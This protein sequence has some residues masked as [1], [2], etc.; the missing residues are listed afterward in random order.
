MSGPQG[1]PGESAYEIYKRVTG[2]SLNEAEWIASLKGER[3]EKGETGTAGA[4]GPQ[5][6]AG[7][8]G[9]SDVISTVECETTTTIVIKPSFQNIEFPSAFPTSYQEGLRIR[10]SG[11]GGYIEGKITSI[12]SVT[13]L[14]MDSDNYSG[15]LNSRLNGSE[16]RVQS[17]SPAVRAGFLFGAGKGIQKN[18]TNYFGPG[19]TWDGIGQASADIV[20]IPSPSGG[21]L[22]N[23]RVNL[24][25]A[26]T[27]GTRY[28]ITVIVSKNGGPWNSPAS[29]LTCP[30]QLP[31]TRR[32]EQ[33]G[34]NAT[35]KLSPGDL[36]AVEV[37][38]IGGTSSGQTLQW[39]VT[40]APDG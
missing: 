6:P 3:G 1:A 33:L 16:C 31:D 12:V 40:L 7:R 4:V 28:E 25:G 19:M 5:G 21:V 15:T 11:D 29:D 27:G 39:S 38:G 18:S 34:V 8:D 17:I 14:I 13:E 9:R 20:A 26:T 32:C 23:L 35:L 10:V 36:I 30:I 37:K 22:S 2:G 24:A